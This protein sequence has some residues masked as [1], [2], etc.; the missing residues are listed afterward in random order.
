[1]A[2]ST[3]PEG[4][5]LR[6]PPLAAASPVK[7]GAPD[8]SAA[9]VYSLKLT[10]EM[11][12]QLVSAGD[13]ASIQ[14]AS[15]SAVLTVAGLDPFKF[16]TR[17]IGDADD[18]ARAVCFSR[19]GPA[20][21]IVGPITAEMDLD[22]EKTVQVQASSIAKMHAM[23]AKTVSKKRE[24]KMA[25][26]LPG[27]TKKKQ[28]VRNAPEKRPRAPARAS[29]PSTGLSSSL[30]PKAPNTRSLRS[31]PANGSPFDESPV[32]SPGRMPGSQNA[33]S[34]ARQN[35]SRRNTPT[36]AGGMSNGSGHAAPRRVSPNGNSLTAGMFAK[37]NRPESGEGLRPNLSKASLRSLT[38]TKPTHIS[39]DGSRGLSPRPPSVNSPSSPKTGNLRAKCE[40][41]EELQTNIM[42]ILAS[43]PRSASDVASRVLGSDG[44]DGRERVRTVLQDVAVSR[45]GVFMLKG[46]LWPQ[47][48]EDYPS[49]SEIE[50]SRMKVA[51]S[52]YYGVNGTA[53]VGT[54]D[55]GLMTDVQ[56]E[57]EIKSFQK[58]YAEDKSASVTNE[59]DELELRKSFQKWYPVYGA[60]IYR[61]EGMSKLFKTLDK[62]YRDSRSSTER[63]NLVKRITLQYQKNNVQR[64]E[65]TNVLPLLHAK[66]GA[67]RDAL[68]EWAKEAE[69]SVKA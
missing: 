62:K 28:R 3:I 20:L 32:V 18:S 66:L 27:P 5:T 8:S 17:P 67:I 10:D 12:D 9:V 11:V 50:R 44:H 52:E 61:L 30:A 68:E 65:L 69:G 57:S 29:R 26:N 33:V 21:R 6:L 45:N 54:V 31:A 35:G 58:A 16:S 60:V 48:S 1:M 14:F 64:E 38:P 55:A 2:F 13:D 15:S 37:G 36:G 42:H 4:R 7:A 25:D 34:G 40:D 22:R 41:I 51:R 53:E 46:H 43:N 39:P 56:L 47:I 59:K 63:E 19:N 49:Y 23:R 24:M